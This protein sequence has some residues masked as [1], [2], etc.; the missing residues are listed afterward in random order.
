MEIAIPQ[1]P[2]VSNALVFNDNNVI[3]ISNI[4][5]GDPTS[6]IV[7]RPGVRLDL[8][9][10]VENLPAGQ[11][12]AYTFGINNHGDMIGFGQQGSFVLVRVVR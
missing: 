12:L 8:A 9:D 2:T 10:L 11:N 1:L 7:P 3:V 4:S 6:Y 5:T